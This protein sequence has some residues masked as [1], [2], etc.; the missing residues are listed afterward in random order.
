MQ[1]PLIYIT[2]DTLY[3]TKVTSGKQ[4][5]W[6]IPYSSADVNAIFLDVAT[7]LGTNTFQIVLADNTQRLTPA[8]GEDLALSYQRTLSSL[9]YVPVSVRV[10]GSAT[11]LEDLI[12][13][14]HYVG[15]PTGFRVGSLEDLQDHPKRSLA[16]VLKTLAIV[17]AAILIATGAW[18]IFGQTRVDNI[19]P[20]PTASPIGLSPTPTPTSSPVVPSPSNQDFK[21]EIQNGSGVVGVGSKLSARLE[22]EGFVVG[23]VGNAD[24]YNYTNAVLMAKAGTPKAIKEALQKILVDPAWEEEILPETSPYDLV[25]VIGKESSLSN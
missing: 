5:F 1:E 17:L 2:K 19:A 14:K 7:T 12:T 22:A 16:P 21:V 20:V 13:P 15:N 10:V 23:D 11:K 25:I 9:G 6:R 4:E 18:M 3:A 24:N 8:S